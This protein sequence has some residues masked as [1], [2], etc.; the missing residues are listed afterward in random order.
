MKKQDLDRFSIGC[1]FTVAVLKIRTICHARPYENWLGLVNSC[2]FYARHT[3][4]IYEVLH[5]SM[6]LKIPG[7][8]L[9]VST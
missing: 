2:V 8:A 9:E 7:G 5:Y 6:D 4:E 1:D 3:R